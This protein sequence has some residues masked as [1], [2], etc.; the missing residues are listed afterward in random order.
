MPLSVC[1]L[2]S[3]ACIF[4]SVHLGITTMDAIMAHP[5][6][7]ENIMIRIVL[8]LRIAYGLEVLVV[9]AVSTHNSHAAIIDPLI[10]CQI[11]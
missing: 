4:W 6:N 7:V 8:G 9:T 11:V 2:A 10:C 5:E 1:A 3:T